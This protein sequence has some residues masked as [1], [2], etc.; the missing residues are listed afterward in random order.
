MFG[1]PGATHS[2]MAENLID[3]YWL[4][5]NPTLLG[6]GVPLFKNIKDRTA[7]T[8]MKSKIFASGVACL[9]YEVN[10]HK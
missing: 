2:L 3:E 8:L 5:I 9:H 10:R 1:S 7:L 6:Q 4:F